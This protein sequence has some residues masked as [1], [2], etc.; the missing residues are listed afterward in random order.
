MPLEAWS[1]VLCILP[2]KFLRD[3][4]I[5]ACKAENWSPVE[6]QLQYLCPRNGSDERENRNHESTHNRR[7]HSFP[8]HRYS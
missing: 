6:P 8:G 4:V 2:A 7:R 1:A 5:R 3:A